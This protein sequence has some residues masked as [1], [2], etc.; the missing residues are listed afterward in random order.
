MITG[1]AGVCVTANPKNVLFATPEM[2]ALDT[3]TT[4][5][6]AATR[7]PARIVPVTTVE[8]ARIRSAT[9]EG[10]TL[11]AFARSNA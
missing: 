6:S 11:A 8:P 2:I 4:A 7:L 1:T 9:L 3:P 10:D 5:A